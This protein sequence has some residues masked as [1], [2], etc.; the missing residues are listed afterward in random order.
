VAPPDTW[1]E[2]MLP[3]AEFLELP[4]D[5]REGR[6]PY[7]WSL[8]RKQQLSRLLVA[9]PMVESCE[10]RR[11]F[12][13]LLRSLAGIGEPEIS[14][15]A[16]EEEVRRDVVGKIATGLMQ[17]AGTGGDA[18][19]ALAGLAAAPVT[20][21]AGEAATDDAMAPWIDTDECTACDECVD[22]NPQIFAYNENRKAIIKDPK[23][24]PYRDLVKA[25]ERCT[26]QVIHPGLPRDRGQKDIEK[27]IKRG[28]KYN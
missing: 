12:W 1:N 21:G 25:A 3:L 23:G 17:L 8:D 24:G 7:L 22:L 6:F 2:N 14:R 16:I 20:E 4:E 27:W 13:T 11:D 19:A 26:A 18:G 28:E 9:L 10:D 15:E 5:E